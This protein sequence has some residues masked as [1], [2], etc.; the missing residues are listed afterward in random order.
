MYVPAA[1]ISRH[2]NNSGA[3]ALYAQPNKTKASSSAGTEL[4]AE[5]NKVAPKKAAAKKHGKKAYE[6]KTFE[7]SSLELTENKKNVNK[8][9]LVYADLDFP[10]PR[11]GQNPYIHG[12]DDKTVYEEVDLSR[13][14]D[15][16]PDSDDDASGEN[17]K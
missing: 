3:D 12:H 4:Y 16:L 2:I 6:N 9:G 8:D 13:K 11:K 17:K 14:A 15:P 7:D 10:K 5:V 1:D